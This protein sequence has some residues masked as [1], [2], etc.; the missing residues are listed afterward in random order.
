MVKYLKTRKG[1]FYKLK[2]RHRK[3]NK[4]RKNKSRKNKKMIG[5][6]LSEL[7]SVDISK[8]TIILIGEL[9]TNKTD[10]SQYFNIIRKQK[11]I[12]AL[13]L[14]KF[15]EDKTYFYSEAPEQ[16][17]QLILETDNY[18]SSVIV[19]YAITK[20]PIKLSSITSC[21]RTDSSCDDK[22]ADDILSIFDENSN[23]NCITVAIGLLHVPELKRIINEK[24]PDIKIIV[25]NTVSDKQ[26]NPLIPEVR[27]KHPLVIDL[28][29]VEPPYELP[30]ET[31]IVDVLYNNNNQKIYKCP[32]CGIKSGTQAPINP[33]NT[34]L[35]AHKYDCPNKNKIPKENEN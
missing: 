31:F 33:N 14:D 35:F 6:N 21:D 19:Q 27:R 2:K 11:E 24:R 3:K 10:L 13:S 29:R 16:F 18:S 1:Y 25:I 4:T 34:S 20:I 23:I 28:L 22:Y 17:R 32:I 7:D 5:G 30:G 8:K 26:L 9:H 12:I 15:G